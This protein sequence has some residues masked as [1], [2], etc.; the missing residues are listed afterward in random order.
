MIL[1]AFPFQQW[2]H[3]SARMLPYAYMACLDFRHQVCGI[4]SQ[5]CESLHAQ[6]LW[7]LALEI[8]TL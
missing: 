7:D 2:L 5:L 6:G 8:R 3:E 4:F 1:I